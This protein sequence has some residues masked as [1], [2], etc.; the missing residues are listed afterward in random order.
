MPKNVILSL[1]EHSKDS[2]P[3]TESSPAS[4]TTAPVTAPIPEVTAPLT[5]EVT[6][7]YDALSPYGAWVVVP[8]YGWCW[9]PTVVVVNPGWRP[10]CDNGSW[11]WSDSGWYW[12]SS[13]SWGWAPFHYGRWFCHGNRGWFWAPDRVWGPSWVCWRNSATHCGWAPLPPGACFTAGVGWSHWGRRV[14]SDCHFGIAS[15]HFSFVAHSR[16]TDHHVGRHRLQ[17]HD[18]NTAFAQTKVI[19]HYSWGENNRVFNH[20]IGREQIAA[21]RGSAIPQVAVSDARP[22]R[23]NIVGRTFTAGTLANHSTTSRGHN[24]QGRTV[25]AS[26]S[27]ETARNF[28]SSGTTVQRGLQY[29]ALTRSSATPQ[30]RGSYAATAS[31]PT[32]MARSSFSTQPQQNFSQRAAPSFNSARSFAPQR[33]IASARSYSAP[34]AQRSFGSRSA[35]AAP[36]FRGGASTFGGASRGGGSISRGGGGMSVGRSASTGRH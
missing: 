34:T 35:A 33:S 31:G 18:A 21:A 32:T 1:I 2:T 11:L 29:S 17:G 19:N 6:D 16:F 36:S 7:F 14:D 25:T 26:I 20:G 15:A 22:Q 27:P 3:S 12:N 13:Y 28:A 8:D 24:F 10:Y 5:P 30:F 4:T 23:G 9:Q